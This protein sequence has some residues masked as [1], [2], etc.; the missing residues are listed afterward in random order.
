VEL[1]SRVSGNQQGRGMTHELF[2]YDKLMRFCAW[3]AQTIMWAS[4]RLMV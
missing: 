1:E 3:M 2:S 4:A